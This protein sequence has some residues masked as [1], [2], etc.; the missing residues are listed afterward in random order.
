ME[1]YN[2][3]ECHLESDLARAEAILQEARSGPKKPHLPTIEFYKGQAEAYRK[4]LYLL[5]TYPPEPVT[6][7]WNVSWRVFL[8]IAITAGSITCVF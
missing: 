3:V 4:A 5:E 2:E 7:E 1:E 8:L 6:K